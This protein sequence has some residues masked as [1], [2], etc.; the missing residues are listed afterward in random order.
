MEPD[1]WGAAPP[2]PTPVGLLGGTPVPTTLLN[3][4]QRAFIN[5]AKYGVVAM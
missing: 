3:P 2:P 4:E 5:A 1:Y